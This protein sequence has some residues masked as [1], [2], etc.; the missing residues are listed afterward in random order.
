MRPLLSVVVPVLNEERRLPAT[1]VGL[2]YALRTVSH[3]TEIVVV[4]NGS[5]DGTADVVREHRSGSVPIRMVDCPERGKGAAVR[6]GVLAGD[7][8][9][10][11][12][13][14]AD[15]A[16]NMDALLPALDQLHAGCNVVVGSRAHPDSTV[17]ARHSVV[18]K[19]G[20]WVFRRVAGSL[21]PGVADTQCGFKFFDRATATAL[22]LPLRTTGFA[23]DVELLARAR[24]AGAVVLEMPVRWTDVPG[25]TFSPMRDGY[26]SFAALA[27]IRAMLRSEITEISGINQISGITEV[28]AVT[29]ATVPVGQ[30]VAEV[31]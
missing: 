4:D 11:G 20:A 7:S 21:V 1:L 2:S 9:F 5:T 18:R 28:A 27:E 22:F 25:S 19:A 6:A 13:C 26:R 29:E 17:L 31:A 3:R 15:L 16:T 24:R 30:P 14:D 12:Y 23:F 8:H 10:V